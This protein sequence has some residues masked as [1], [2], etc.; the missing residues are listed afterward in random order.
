MTAA[1]AAGASVACAHCRLP[2]PPGLLV[3]GAEV[4]FCCS[5]CRSVY[6]ILHASG[7]A[8]YYTMRDADPDAAL[9]SAARALA[10][11]RSY[12]ECDDPA[13]LK[14]HVELD[15]GGVAETELYLEGVHC[16]ACVW[17]VERLGRVAPGVIEAR[18]NLPKRLV[19]VR[20]DPGR[21]ALSRI[22]QRLDSLGYPPH[23]P[24]A[25][26]ADQRALR[27]AEDQ[28]DLI[29]IGVAGAC[30]GNAMLVAA[31]LYAGY[32]SSMEPVF[33]TLFRYIS[34]VLGLVA[35][36]FPGRVFFRG[37]WAAC[38]TRTPHLDAPIALGLLAGGVAGVVNTLLGRGEIY[39]DSLCVLVFLL[40]VGRYLQRRQ[41]SR[42]DDAVEGLY[43]L[44]PSIA[45]RVEIDPAT[46][47]EMIRQVPIEAL[48]AD[49]GRGGEG[50]GELVEIRAGESVP[51]DGI[52]LS[53]Q[54]NVD[55]GLLT[56]ESQPVAVGP[57]DRLCAGTLNLSAVLRVRVEAAGDQTRVGKLMALV[58]QSARNK[59]PMV[60]LADRISGYFLLGVVV[61]ALGTLGYWL[62]RGDTAATDH[63]VA[64]VIV[65][66]PCALG[67]ATPLAVG[68][69]LGRAAR[70]GILIKGGAALEHLARGGAGGGTI[71]LD[72]TGTLTAGQIALVSWRGDEMLKP[73][74]AA[75]EAQ[76]SHPI[77]QAFGRALS[78]LARPR[79]TQVQQDARGG[80]EGVVEGRTLIIGSPAY[81]QMRGIT[82]PT[83]AREAIVETLAE[84]LTPV[85]I[86]RDGQA[87]AVAGFGD[88]LRPEARGLCATLRAQGWKLAILSGD[89]PEIV[90][91]VA[92]ALAID[93]ARGGLRPED[94][95]AL[96]EAARSVGPTVMI[97][98]G[99]NDAGAL[100]AATVGIAVH[101]GAE[102]SLAAADIYLSQPGLAAIAH[103]LTAARQTVRT[104]RW[105]LA[106]SLTYN[107][108]AVSLAMLGWINPLLAALIMPLSSLTVVWL[109]VG[110]R[111]FGGR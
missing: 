15:A 71:Y 52:V 21:I 25:R 40:L 83:W 55:Q 61:L 29:R 104:I 73:A 19:Q 85:L 110:A 8:R 66:C 34:M 28:R 62:W 80:I 46:G 56:G 69:A 12:A 74:V 92:R 72:K 109:A 88:P 7:M 22:A 64:L 16:S 35:L 98:D 95:L 65:A 105:G 42:A 54:S 51:V 17:L 33:T 77:A 101:G 58:A 90:G 78:G 24:A 59:A 32:L 36:L 38:R 18:L 68:V 103:L 14:A 45:H 84:T 1:S 94:K 5:G 44:T 27:R 3:E 20:W 9:P 100:A 49:V 99:V 37:A 23:P 60:L 31:A 4:Q 67:L 89:H 47:A 79:A 6:N 41:Q 75:I 76:A 93:D 39:F 86:A 53:G 11:G 57:G 107:L 87:A 81:L 63:A 102:A 91:H 82:L 13:F 30:A 108:L 2:V 26:S 10:T 96:L 50:G 106:L 97:G 48:Q 70:R 43:C 111:T